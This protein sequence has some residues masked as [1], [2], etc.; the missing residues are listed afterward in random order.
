MQITMNKAL[1]I[2]NDPEL[3]NNF[4]YF[5]QPPEAPVTYI[6]NNGPRMG[7]AFVEIM[8]RCLKI[9]QVWEALMLCQL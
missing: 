9:L 8:V 7:M 4:V 1:G 6:K 5:N 2:E 3:V